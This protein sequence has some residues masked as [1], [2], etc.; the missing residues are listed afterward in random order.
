MPPE[1][2]RVVVASIHTHART[3]HALKE[4]NA[5]LRSLSPVTVPLWVN[6]RERGDVRVVASGGEP[7]RASQVPGGQYQV[8]EQA[9][10]GGGHVAVTVRQEVFAGVQP[11][12]QD[13]SAGAGQ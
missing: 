13:G 4:G 5:A 3:Q 2:H 8:A 9:A 11:G 6:P 1:L 7:G 12:Q 10:A